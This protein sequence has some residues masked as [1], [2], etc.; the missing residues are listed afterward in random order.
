MPGSK[1]QPL[2]KS[3]KIYDQLKK[4]ALVWLPAI[5]TL[6]FALAG[7]WGLP[8]ADEVVGSIVAFDTF[9]GV[10]LHISN[11]QYNNSDAKYDGSI[12]L[13]EEADAVN[14]KMDSDAINTKDE[15]TLKVNSDGR[16]AG[17]QNKI[18]VKKSTS[19]K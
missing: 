11:V 14:F 17:K 7:I 15:V 3:N 16:A 9:L 10:V 12:D 19:S 6:Y 13:N 2:I 18:K 5:G 8:H 1:N 4:F